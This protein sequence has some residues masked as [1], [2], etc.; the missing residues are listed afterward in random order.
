LLSPSPAACTHTQVTDGGA[1]AGAGPDI[2]A[3]GFQEVVPLNAGNA[4]LGPT[5]E[6]ADAWDLALAATLNGEEW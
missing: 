5:S 6:G 1:R 2:I 4:L 3:V